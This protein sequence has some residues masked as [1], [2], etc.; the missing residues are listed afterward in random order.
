MPR[1]GSQG[2]KVHGEGPRGHIAG[3]GGRFL[4]ARGGHSPGEPLLVSLAGGSGQVCSS[5]CAPAGTTSQVCPNPQ[6]PTGVPVFL[7][8]MNRAGSL[9]PTG[10]SGW[11][12]RVSEG[13]L[14]T[15]L[16][17]Q[18]GGQCPPATTAALPGGP[19]TLGS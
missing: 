11:A 7:G 19:A 5:G 10:V 18:P 1:L 16:T 2:L 3:S 13:S 6:P 4:E 17:P 8:G 9:G 15:A 12:S 14:Q